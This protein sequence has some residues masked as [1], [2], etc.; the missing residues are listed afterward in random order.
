M[1]G[2]TLDLQAGVPA[3]GPLS[4]S[5]VFQWA[6]DVDG[7]KSRETGKSPRA[8]LWIPQSCTNLEAVV[9]ANDNMLE[10]PLLAEPDFR[11]ELAAANCG[12]VL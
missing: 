2:L 7:V 8:Y 11:R 3:A 9:F 1:L 5:G 6:V 12:I 4:E 10:E